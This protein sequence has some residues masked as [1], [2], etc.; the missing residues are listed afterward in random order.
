MKKHFAVLLT[1]LWTA[2]LGAFAF[3]IPTG[4]NPTAAKV[5]TVTKEATKTIT[6][7]AINDK[8]K[9][10]NCQFVKEKSD[11]VTCDLNKIMKYLTDWKGGLEGTG[12]TSDFD[13]HAE[14]SAEN[15]DLAWKR[16]SFI[17]GKLKQKVSYWDWWSHK[18]TDNGDGLKIWISQD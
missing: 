18:T 3:D 14:A 13:I 10:E 4:G 17:E 6:T 5:K 11:Q 7:S 8:L 1:V 2:P 15:N 12:V 16:V 9:K